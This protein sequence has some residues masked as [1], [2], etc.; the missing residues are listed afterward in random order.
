MRAAFQKEHKKGERF[1]KLFNERH[2]GLN[3]TFD[4]T[5]L[6]SSFVIFV[7]LIFGYSSLFIPFLFFLRLFLS[8]SSEFIPLLRLTSVCFLHISY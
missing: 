8:Q 5:F 3:T 7:Y 2:S 6:F 1:S 4:L